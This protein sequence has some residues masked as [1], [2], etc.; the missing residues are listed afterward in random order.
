MPDRLAYTT[1]QPETVPILHN[2]LLPRAAERE[3]KKVR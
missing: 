3:S 1:S 2:V